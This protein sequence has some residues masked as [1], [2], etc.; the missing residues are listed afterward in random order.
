MKIAITLSELTEPH[1][2]KLLDDS[3]DDQLIYTSMDS[4]EEQNA[5][6]LITELTG[7]S[8]FKLLQHAQIRIDS[9]LRTIGVD[10][11]VLYKE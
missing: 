11:L 7:N 6:E 8:L 3:L 4:R 5:K 10:E 9:D 2:K 1:Y